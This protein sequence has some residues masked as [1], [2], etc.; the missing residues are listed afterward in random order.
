MTCAT[1]AAGGS[2]PRHRLRTSAALHSSD[3]SA[4]RYAPRRPPSAPTSA[5]SACR[6]PCRRTRSGA[7]A[8]HV[9]DEQFGEFDAR[10]R[11]FGILVD[12]VQDKREDQ[13]D[14]VEA[15]VERVGDAALAIP[16]RLPRGGDDGVPQ[17]TPRFAGIGVRLEEFAER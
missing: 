12:P 17:W 8:V 3:P 4:A 9:V 7:S 6:R 11:L 10:A 16:V 1:P 15:P 13:A 2:L 14:H 5:R